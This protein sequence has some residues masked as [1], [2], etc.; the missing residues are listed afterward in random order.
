MKNQQLTSLITELKKAAI[1]QK[2][3]L[4][5]RI[6]NDLDKPTSKRR[7]VNLSRINR[8]CKDNEV[9]VVPGKVLSVG[10]LDKKLTIAAYDFSGNAVQKITKSGSKAIT[11]YEL[12]K[13]N[14]N[15]SKVR[16]IG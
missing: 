2:V 5:K 9:I 3:N 1:I 7:I 8:Y 12:L 14:P 16:I 13:K 10:E 15:G 11:I 6:A 4:W